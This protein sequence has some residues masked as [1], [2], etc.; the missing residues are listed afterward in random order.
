MAGLSCFGPFEGGFDELPG[1][2]GGRA[3]SAIRASSATMR[4]GLGGD[5]LLGGR[6]PPEERD[7]Q[8]ILFRVAQG[9]EVGGGGHP[10]VRIDPP[11]TVSNKIS[12]V[13][14]GAAARL[15]GGNLAG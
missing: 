6:Q 12:R 14:G 9:G 3:S 15:S 4:T 11:V 8:R 7:D 1:V 2:F 10:V 13:I 5:A